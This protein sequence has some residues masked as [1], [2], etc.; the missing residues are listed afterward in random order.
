MLPV[1]ITLLCCVITD[2]DVIE[3]EQ[4]PKSAIKSSQIHHRWYVY[5]RFYH[6]RIQR[7]NTKQQKRCRR[8]LSNFEYLMM[9]NHLAGRSF[10]DLTQYPVMPWVLCDYMS[11]T[12]DLKDKN[13]YRDLSKPIGAV[14][15][16]RASKFI[17]RFESLK[18]VGEDPFMYGTCF[19][20]LTYRLMVPL[21]PLRSCTFPMLR[22][23]LQ[24]HWYHALLFVANAT[25]YD[26][27]FEVSRRPTRSW[28]VSISVDNYVVNIMIASCQ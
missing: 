22:H 26:L 8:E 27:Q 15:E 6:F 10:N 28:C 5:L 11:D 2:V 24:L 13:I 25:V 19:L 16:E 9:L 23:S 18:E 3:L 21:H 4:D 14:N 17:A 1:L 20:R 12:I 7:T